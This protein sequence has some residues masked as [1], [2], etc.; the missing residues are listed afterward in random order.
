[1]GTIINAAAVIVGGLLGMLVGK[2]LKARFQQI[3]M[4]AMGLSVIFIAVGGVLEQMLVIEDGRL[5]TQGTMMMIVSLTLGALVGEAINIEYHLER[6]GAWLKRRT[7]SDGDAGFVGSFVTASLTICIGAMAVVGAIQDGLLG[8]S[9]LLITKAILDCVIILVM[10]ASQGKGCIFAAIP[11][12]AFQGSITLLSRFLAP[13]MTE[14]ALSNLSL[15]GSVL[16][17]CVGIN[18][19]FDKHIRTA[20]MLPAIVFAV[21]CTLV[22]WF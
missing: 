8:D 17:F 6:F 14:Q 12:F 1:M 20:N 10:T 4:C 19:T 7:G 2:R 22:P 3:I 11:V 15:V 18:L 16:V 13:V 21:A 9:S 5:G